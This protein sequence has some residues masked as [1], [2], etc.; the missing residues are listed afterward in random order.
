MIGSRLIR[1]LFIWLSLFV[2]VFACTRAAPTPTPTLSPEQIRELLAQTALDLSDLPRGYKL[3]DSGVYLSNEE[4][5]K[6]SRLGQ[7]VLLPKYEEWG[8]V[9]G[10]SISYRRGGI[11]LLNTVDL[12]RDSAGAISSLEWFPPEYP[13]HEEYLADKFVFGSIEELG[14]VLSA[15]EV[16]VEEIA[17]P[18][19]GDLSSAFKV[20]PVDPFGL[21]L[22]SIHAE[23]QVQDRIVGCAAMVDPDPG[24]MMGI[25]LTEEPSP[26]NLEDVA[27]ALDRKMQTVEPVD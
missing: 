8:R 21:S 27:R 25:D 26:E 3:A 19:F 9:M 4:A 5:A 10:Y 23:C 20:S 17:F 24:R 2:L 12:Y 6:L 14:I 7:L 16:K 1:V 22:F 11:V 13:T 15:L 18:K